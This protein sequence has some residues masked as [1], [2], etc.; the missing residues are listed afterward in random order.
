MAQYFEIRWWKRYLK[1]KDVD[2]YLVNKK[3]YW[4]RLLHQMSDTVQPVEGM[5]I[6][7]AG[8][9]P[10]GVFIVF[11]KY[12]VKAID[13]LLDQYREGLAHFTPAMYPNV[14]FEAIA[15]EHFNEHEQYDLVF[16][17]N[18]INHVSDLDEAFLRLYNS[19]KKGSKLIVSIDAHNHGFFK[20]LFRL[21]PGDILHPHQYDLPEYEQM[22]TK[23]NCSILQTLLV[24][25]EFFF[26]H[27]MIVAQKN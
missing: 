12:E 27:Y 9:G 16:C 7:D 14:K 26:S 25:R 10:A 3:K 5:K 13:P 23:L 22:L 1:D 11:D 20:H 8:C 4:H 18:A 24:K 2:T 17:I 6:L 15:L 21:Q 19:A